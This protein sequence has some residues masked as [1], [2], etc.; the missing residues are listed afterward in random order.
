MTDPE[1]Q[2]AHLASPGSDTLALPVAVRAMLAALF[3][4]GAAFAA[5]QVAIAIVVGSRFGPSGV[6]VLL[7]AGAVGRIF[8]PRVELLKSPPGL[9]PRTV[10]L[11]ASVAP[12][13]VILQDAPLWLLAVLMA[14]VGCMSV[15]FS[16]TVMTAA[17]TAIPAGSS[18]GMFGQAIGMFAAGTAALAGTGPA[19][20]VAFIAT[21]LLL[22][23]PWFLPVNSTDSG[24]S[25]SSSDARSTEWVYPFFLAL[26]SY[27]PLGLFAALVTVEFGP[28]WVGPSFL[29]YAAGSLVAARLT[30]RF[31]VEPSTGALLAAVGSLL[32]VVGFLSLPVTL[33]AR[34]LSGVLLF[35]A[36]GTLL[37]RAGHRG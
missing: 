20:V 12:L 24:R 36:Q 30:E 16:S 26:C 32:W 37:R 8:A 22:T 25:P 9:L 6:G 29:V 34:F 28:G 5:Q 35:L 7:A 2:L 33:V 18:M 31:D 4:N 3:L 17:P 14:P 27:G 11:V 21:C 19:L 23:V 1:A 13:L 15:L 10:G